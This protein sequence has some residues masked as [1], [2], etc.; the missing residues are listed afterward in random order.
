[1]KLR[2]VQAGVYETEDGRYRI[3]HED[4]VSEC[5]HPQCEDLH[6]KFFPAPGFGEPGMVHPV[7]YTNWQIWDTVSD[8]YLDGGEEFES[9]REAEMYLWSHLNQKVS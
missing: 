2:R 3:E 5:S 9:K 7:A 6:R 1:M 4:Y 8:N